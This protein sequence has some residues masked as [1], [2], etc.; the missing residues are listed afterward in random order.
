MKIGQQ[1]LEG[2][3]RLPPFDAS[4]VGPVLERI[5]GIPHGIV[6]L[7]QAQCRV[8]VEEA[9]EGFQYVSFLPPTLTYS[10]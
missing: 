8:A 9:Y 10:H 5:N 6:S 2:A 7:R 1:N 3:S 4:L